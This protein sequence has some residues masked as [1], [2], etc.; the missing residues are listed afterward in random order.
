M[1]YPT[2]KTRRFRLA[3]TFLLKHDTTAILQFKWVPN[4]GHHCHQLRRLED[5]PTFF[6]LRLL[7]IKY[8]GSGSLRRS[9][10]YLWVRW[11]P[12]RSVIRNV[13]L[14]SFSLTWFDSASVGYL[15][16]GSMM[17]EL[18]G[19]S[20]RYSPPKP[21]SQPNVPAT[22][23]EIKKNSGDSPSDR[24]SSVEVFISERSGKQAPFL[25]DRAGRT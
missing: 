9:S 4:I 20:S 10:Y 16:I 13:H 17:P 19:Y 25:Y 18:V 6:I 14:W 11:G 8:S 22:P 7:A 5:I 24:K 2:H 15:F 23:F 3:R 12:T 21:Q 1:P